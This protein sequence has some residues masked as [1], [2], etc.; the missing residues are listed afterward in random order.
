MSALLSL[1]RWNKSFLRYTQILPEL[2]DAEF[3][4]N[5]LILNDPW[6]NTFVFQGGEFL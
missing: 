6:L 5:I 2:F 1:Q 3:F 4:G